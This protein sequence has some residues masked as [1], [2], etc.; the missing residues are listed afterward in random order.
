[1]NLQKKYNFNM[2][3]VM[4]YIGFCNA[5]FGEEM[6]MV[7]KNRFVLLFLE[8]KTKENDKIFIKAIL[9]ESDLMDRAHP[10]VLM[11]ILVVTECVKNEKY[12][13][14]LRKNIKNRMKFLINKI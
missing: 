12:L 13:K 6:N 14:P 1:M 3:Q 5:I 8:K 11:S 2:T 7:D 10:S 9:K 4:E